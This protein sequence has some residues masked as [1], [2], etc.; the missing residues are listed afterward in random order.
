MIIK[1]GGP[2]YTNAKQTIPEVFKEI[3]KNEAARRTL[4]T[5]EVISFEQCQQFRALK[6]DMDK[7]LRPSAERALRWNTDKGNAAR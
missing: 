2:A 7:N 3:I 1:D 6:D 5:P 4:S